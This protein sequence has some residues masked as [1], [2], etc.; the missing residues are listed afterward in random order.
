MDLFYL[1]WC[2]VLS[3]RLVNFISDLEALVED[4]FQF[5]LWGV[6]VFRLNK[7]IGMGALRPPLKSLK[8]LSLSV[9]RACWL[10][11]ETVWRLFICRYHS[12]AFIPWGNSAPCWLD[13]EL[14]SLRRS[15]M[16]CSW[17]NFKIWRSFF[18]NG[19]INWKS[20]T[21][22]VLIQWRL[23]FLLDQIFINAVNVDVFL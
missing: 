19:R 21:I 20:T 10:R 12:N 16:C 4:C 9:L 11:L 2:H 15:F 22:R 14:L 18:V 23:W 6:P 1:G 5:E 8:W 7:R 17:L 13:S 3:H